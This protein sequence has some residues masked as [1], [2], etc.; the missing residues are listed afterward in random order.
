MKKSL[1]YSAAFLMLVSCGKSNRFSISGEVT[2]GKGDTLYFEHVGMNE[3]SVLDSAILSSDGEFKFKQQQPEF[4]PEFYRLRLK[5][6]IIN[7]S[8]DSTEEISIKTDVKKFATV[9]K[10]EGSENCSQIQKLNS[11]AI[12]AK[13]QLDSLIRLNQKKQ[14]T[15]AQFD[16]SLLRVLGVYKSEASKFIFSNP[17]SGAAYFALFQKIHSYLIFNPY[18]KEDLR[19]FAAVATSYDVYRPKSPRT[20]HLKEFTLQA[21]KATRE[22]RAL[23]VKEE[24]VSVKGSFEISLP[25]MTGRTQKLSSQ[26]GKVVVLCFTAY[27]SKFSPEL[28]MELGEI[29][30]ANKAKGMEIYQVSLDSEE[31]FWKVSASN[32]PWKCVR[33]ADGQYS[34]FAR[35]YNVSQLPTVFILNR[36]G[37]VVKRVENLKLLRSE[38]EKML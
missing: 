23:Q 14:I 30:A 33:D 31:H 38:I 12:Q 8:V 16:S 28:N 5:D 24:Q 34:E 36:Q 11:S 35:T 3:V 10:V 20:K 32:L 15:P 29:Y 19:V 4:A 21:M 7:L 37:E 2:G 26:I 9:Y 25:D 27:Q 18:K 1:L 6:Q 22:P 17:K 13:V